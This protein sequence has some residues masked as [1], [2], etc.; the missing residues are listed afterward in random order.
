MSKLYGS[1]DG[2]GRAQA[3]TRCAHRETSAAA[4]SWDG[5]VTVSLRICDDGCTM[6]EI[7]VAGGSQHGGRVIYSAPIQKLLEATY[8]SDIGRP[9]NER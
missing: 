3:R 4:R 9:S 1:L 6:A 7:E 2:D 5:S 8:L